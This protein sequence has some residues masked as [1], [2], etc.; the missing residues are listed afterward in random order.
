M[1]LQGYRHRI[2]VIDRSGSILGI[3]QGQQDGLREFFK[4]E[5]SVPGKA[6]YSLWDF[7]TEV[8]RVH[9][10]APLDDV[11]GYQIEPRGGTALYDAVGAAVSTEGEALA[12]LPE[13]QRPE[14]VVVIVSSDGEE[15]SS[16]RL[17]GAGVK[18][19][20]EHQQ[21]TY[22]WRVLYMGFGQAAFDEGERVGARGGLTVNSVASD[23]GSRN[24]WKMSAGYLSR[25][26][27]AA[28][29]AGQGIFTDLTPEERA[30]GESG[31]DLG[32]TAGNSGD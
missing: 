17:T 26:P 27:Y 25:V 19:L 24:S 6:T 10:L 16:C 22:Q 12:A 13:D 18:A 21:G 15:N 9:A 14:D 31:D 30:L 11:Q 8:R 2:L 29:A 23:A 5:A 4:S 32:E 3:L 1:T 20:L 28:A 7:D